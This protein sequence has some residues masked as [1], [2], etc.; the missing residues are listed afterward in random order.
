MNLAKKRRQLLLSI[1]IAFPQMAA[2]QAPP[3]SGLATDAPARGDETVAV[4]DIVVTAQ[5]RSS[6]VQETPLAITAVGGD[7]I[8]AR[9]ITDLQSLA[10][11]LP[12][13]NFGRNVGFARIAIRGLGLDTTVAGQEGRVAYHSDGVYI[14]RPT[15]QLAT[16]F[17][18][19][20]VE[21]VRGPQGTLYGRN[22]T[23]GAINVITNDPT[24]MSEG[25]LKLSAGNYGLF[26]AEGAI[27]GAATD[28]I[29]GRFAFQA[30]RRSG[31]GENVTTGEDIDNERRIGVRGKIRFQPSTDF[32]IVLSAD[33]SYVN[34]SA[35]VYHYIGPGKPGVTPVGPALG[36]A[37]AVDPRDTAGN[38]PQRNM[39]RFSGVSATMDYDLG[40]ATLT[41]VAAYRD[42][43][44]ALRFDADGTPVPVGD[45][46]INEAA[47][48]LSEEMRFAGSVG[49]LDWI[50]GGY[51][52]SERIF[53]QTRISPVRSPISR[54]QVLGVDYQGRFRTDAY[55][56]FGQFDY[57]IVDGLKLT[58]GLRYS[59]ETKRIDQFGVVDLFTPYS[60]SPPYPYNSFQ[61]DRTSFDATT[62]R[63]GIEYKPAKNILAYISYAKGFK[64]G[65]YNLGTAAPPVRPEKLTDYEGG[66]KTQWFDNK[67]QLNLAAFYYDYT[68]LQVQKV[69]GAA[70][71]TL[72]N[73]ATSRVKGLEAEFIARP[74]SGLEISANGA[75]LDA[76]FTRFA[77][78]DP[79]RLELGELDLTGNRLPQAP[80]Y[81]GNL[82][83]QYRTRASLGELT[84]RGEVTYS[85]R[86]FF[87][88]FNRPEVSQGAYA[89]GNVFATLALDS[90][91]TVAAFVRNIADKRTISTNQVSTGLFGFP[92]LGAYD[93][94]RTFGGSV[95]V[96]F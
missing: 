96:A 25:Y 65:G 44:T 87:S 82:A 10:P 38:V 74:I 71:V 92:I 95:S 70:V 33:Y 49:R 85:D 61:K 29:S 9:Q 11:S 55:A 47:H 52:F 94:P 89:K 48:Q 6:T 66:I 78:S 57:E 40:F 32:S 4:T 2:A 91:V 90:G 28:T 24:D 13:V 22:A 63:F 15:A 30:S 16:F 60:P 64:S 18:I 27:S 69:Q 37:V 34:D 26:S 19:D 67:L 50:V 68:D 7:E 76:R 45:F 54:A 56:A 80:K 8:G 79:A 83:V 75:W 20:R 21:V 77:T 31:Y 23:A 58:A 59:H 41:S 53:G 88:P 5:K 86:V 42:S 72:V 35:N 51:Y 39:Q 93:P 3:A 36:G 14:S 81:T 12:N 73:A 62:P 84:L 1:A 43:S 46:Q 17:D